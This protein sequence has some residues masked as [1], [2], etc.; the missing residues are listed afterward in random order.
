MEAAYRASDVRTIILR[1]GNFIDPDSDDDVMRLLL[2]RDIRRGR[3]TRA[4]GA[5]VMQ[6]YAYVPDWARAAV[7]LAEQRAA[8]DSFA[9]IPFPGHTFTIT[10]LRAELEQALD[11]TLRVTA[12]PWWMMRLFSPFW[13]LA[14][15]LGECA[16]SGTRPIGS[17][18]RRSP[19][20]SQISARRT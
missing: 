15:E 12:F 16:T 11:Q 9:D 18:T 2:L 4:G 10:E 7:M 17:R 8:L 3:I 20:S 13:E 5:D 14:R 19:A 1:A 6:A